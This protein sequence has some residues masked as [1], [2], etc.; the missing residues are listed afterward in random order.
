MY[1]QSYTRESQSPY[2]TSRQSFLT[3]LF[4]TVYLPDLR[5]RIRIRRILM[6]LGLPD[7]DPL[8]RDMDPAPAPDPDLSISKQK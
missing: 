3:L 5:T 8:V 4:S 2:M 6:F 7:P 1:M